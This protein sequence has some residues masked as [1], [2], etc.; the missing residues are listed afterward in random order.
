MQFRRHDHV[1]IVTRYLDTGNLKVLICIQ[2]FLFFGL[3][4]QQIDSHESLNQEIENKLG[5]HCFPGRRA[6]SLD[7]VQHIVTCVCAQTW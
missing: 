4:W 5:K 6:K 7:K 2:D 1:A 3:K